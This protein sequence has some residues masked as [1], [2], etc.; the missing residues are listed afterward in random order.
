MI[1]SFIIIN[2]DFLF[3]SLVIII[4]IISFI[5]TLLKQSH[6]KYYVRGC[7]VFMVHPEYAQMCMRVRIMYV[8]SQ[9]NENK[10]FANEYLSNVFQYCFINII[11]TLS[12]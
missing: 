1:L 2:C 3:K 9:N 12:K 6:V 8:N 5:T 4:I 10:I 11:V 7:F